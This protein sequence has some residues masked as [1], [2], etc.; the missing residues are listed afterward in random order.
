MWGIMQCT[1]K[2]F[3]V[4]QWLCW[5]TQEI[6]GL[7]CVLVMCTVLLPCVFSFRPGSVEQNTKCNE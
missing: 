1:Y 7:P 2:H 4:Q 6:V 5:S 3:I